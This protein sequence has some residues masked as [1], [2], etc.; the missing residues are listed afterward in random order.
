MDLHQHRGGVPAAGAASTNLCDG[1]APSNPFK[2][3]TA[4]NPQHLVNGFAWGLDA[5]PISPAPLALGKGPATV[6]R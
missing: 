4:G 1:F 2:G 3:F 6:G 5:S